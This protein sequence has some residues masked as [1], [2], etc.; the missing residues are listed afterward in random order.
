VR[1]VA[2][3]DANLD[4]LIRAL[5]ISL[6]LHLFALGTWKYGQKHGWWRESHVPHWLQVARDNLVKQ[7]AKPPTQHAQPPQ[8]QT[9]T[10]VE[11]VPVQASEKAPKEAKFFSSANSIASSTTKGDSVL[12][13]LTGDQDKVLKTTENGEPATEAQPLQPTPKPLPQRDRPTPAPKPYN[14]GD[15]VFNRPN[16]NLI[17]SKTTEPETAPRPRPKTV[18]EAKMAQGMRGDP[19]HHDGGS[20]HIALNSTVDARHTAIGDYDRQFVDA[21]QSQWEYLT[22]D[23]FSWPPGEVRLEFTM[24]YDGRITDMKVKYSSVD[25]FYTLLCQKAILDNTPYATWTR[26]MRRELA[27]DKRVVKITFYYLSR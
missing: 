24:H 21:V 27:G 14:P 12:P 23:H 2:A 9:L 3:K 13:H 25:G 5:V 10:F 19:A 22:Q 26:D 16:T 7:M 20:Q 11:V 17:P 4:L 8:Q 6:A 15:L 18:Q 1:A